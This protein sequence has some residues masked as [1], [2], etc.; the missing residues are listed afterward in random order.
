[1]AELKLWSKLRIQRDDG[2]NFRRRVQIDGHT[3]H[4]MCNRASVVVQL[5]DPGQSTGGYDSMLHRLIEN[6]GFALI[7]V[8]KHEVEQDAHAVC[9][10]VLVTCSDRTSA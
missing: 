7:R 3:V 6:H 9:E 4:F 1:M 10:R 5:E 8:T 2:L